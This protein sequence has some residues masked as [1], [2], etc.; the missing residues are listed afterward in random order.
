MSDPLTVSLREGVAVITIDNPPVNAIVL[1]VRA[2]LAAASGADLMRLHD[3][4]ALDAIRV[5]DRIAHG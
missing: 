4:S 2:A 3:P 1:E 5:A